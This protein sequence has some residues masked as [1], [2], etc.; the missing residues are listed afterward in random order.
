MSLIRLCWNSIKHR[1]FKGD[2][3]WISY[4][5]LFEM[6]GREEVVD[7]RQLNS[8]NQFQSL[9]NS[10]VYRFLTRGIGVIFHRKTPRA[11]CP[12][13]EE[14]SSFWSIFSCMT[15]S[16][17]LNMRLI[18]PLEFC[19]NKTMKLPVCSCR[20]GWQ[21]KITHLLHSRASPSR[22]LKMCFGERPVPLAVHRTGHQ[23]VQ[24]RQRRRL[25]HETTGQLPVPLEQPAHGGNKVGIQ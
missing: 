19:F 15:T 17:H 4:A 21:E 2:F 11:S 23:E 24:Q 20:N 10:W 3:C 9:T 12:S 8:L 7:R 18:A 25:R 22:T 16:F 14:R 6:S 13:A 5:D 1:V